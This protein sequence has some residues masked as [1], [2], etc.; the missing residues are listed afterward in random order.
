MA[1]HLLNWQVTWTS[2]FDR[3]APQTFSFWGVA[4][5]LVY[6]E[7]PTTIAQLKQKIVDTFATF[8]IELCQ[9]A[10]RSVSNRLEMCIAAEDEHFEHLKQ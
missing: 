1:G 9:K 2:G 8:D 7:K 10:C 3:V 6:A 5:N 4:K